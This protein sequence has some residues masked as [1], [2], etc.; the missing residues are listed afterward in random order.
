MIDEAEQIV[1]HV[2]HYGWPSKEHQSVSLPPSIKGESKRE[3]RAGRG[4]ESQLPSPCLP[5]PTAS[6]SY[7][8]AEQL[9]QLILVFLESTEAWQ[10]S[11][12]NMETGVW[13][14]EVIVRSHGRMQYTKMCSWFGGT[15]PV[16]LWCGNEH[17]I[18][19]TRIP[20]PQSVTV[21]TKRHH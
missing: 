7:K 2:M 11:F 12:S 1:Y 18:M 3:S 14:S 16:G 10:S 21:G 13:N 17:I 6:A 15:Y 5:A 20:A 19:A 9:P 4:W 8:L